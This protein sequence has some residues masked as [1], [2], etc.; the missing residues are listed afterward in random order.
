MRAT[1]LTAL[2]L[3]GTALN[4]Q[5][6]VDTFPA[7]QGHLPT[8]IARH[9]D[10][11]T[12]L[13]W[14]NWPNLEPHLGRVAKNG[15]VQVQ[16]LEKDHLPAFMAQAPDGSLWI[17]DA[18]KKVLWHVTP[19]GKVEQVSIGRTTLGIAID[20]GGTI[21]STHPESADI[22]RYGADG[23]VQAAAFAGK[24]RAER[25]APPSGAPPAPKPRVTDVPPPRKNSDVALTREQRKA[26]LITHTPTWLVPGED[27]AWF[28]DPK[29]RVVG[30]VDLAGKIAS[31]PLPRDWGQPGRL[32]RGVDGALWFTTS[33]SPLLGR[34][35]SEGE[36]TSVTIPAP[37]K[38]IAG[39]GK[40]RIWFSDGENVGY[41]DAKG[42]VQSVDLPAGER[43]IA[44]MAEGPDGAMWYAD[45]KSR[46]LGKITLGR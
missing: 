34:V 32:A 40:G 45:Q 37:A 17:T 15:K 11:I 1:A 19:K 36:M 29:S 3:L 38:A 5:P 8:E 46:V 21:W 4:A 14:T 7:P 26:L 12:F 10:T 24:R 2:V 20:A 39:D 23:S 9:G 22:T 27:G 41:V 25:V 42:D 13:S 6:R 35:T 31:F 30:R 28:S 33:R 44:S 18:K 43:F 16:A